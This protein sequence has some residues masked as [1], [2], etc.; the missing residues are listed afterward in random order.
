MDSG[1]ISLLSAAIGGL[2]AV[3]GIFINQILEYI[4]W[5]EGLKRKGEDKYIEN[6]LENLHETVV[7]FYESATK[8]LE[9]S[10]TVDETRSRYVKDEIEALDME[11][12]K[13]IA[14][15]S[16]YF[17][18]ELKERIYNVYEILTT[19]RVIIRGEAEGT[20]EEIVT[21]LLWLNEELHQFNDNLEKIMKGYHIKKE[22]VLFKRIAVI[23]V[24]L[25][26]ILAIIICTILF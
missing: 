3:L 18:S 9:L 8:A 24:L 14:Y 7:G 11:V 16:P 4:R 19:I 5:K 20:D 1:L 2:F 25:N 22:G 17:D 6:K 26:F 23:S 10:R 15:S 21:N 12:R 13:R